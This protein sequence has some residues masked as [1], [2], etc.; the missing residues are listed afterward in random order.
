[1]DSNRPPTITAAQDPVAL[2]LFRGPWDERI[3]NA[4]AGGVDLIVPQKFRTV[5]QLRFESAFSEN[6]FDDSYRE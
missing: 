4:V 5:D 2:Y 1:M 6:H 3:P